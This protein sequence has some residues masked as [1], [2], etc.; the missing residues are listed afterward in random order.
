MATSGTKKYLVALDGSKESMA[1]V[2]YVAN[3]MYP[4][5]TQVR[6][7]HVFSRIP[8]SYWDFDPHPESDVWM[9]NLR[10]QEEAHEKEVKNFMNKALK[11]LLKADFREQLVSVEIHDRVNGIA[12]D[13][14]AEAKNNYHAV[15]MGRTGTGKLPGLAAGSVTSKILPALPSLHICVVAGKPQDGNI[16]V[17]IDGSEG[18][19]RAVDYLCSL[20]VRNNREVIL[21]HAMRHIGFTKSQPLQEIEKMVWR[22]AKKTIEPVIA[23]ATKRLVGAGLA[24]SK[25]RRKIVTG[26]NSRAGALIE[27]AKQSKCST[28]MVGRTGVSQVEAFNIGRVSNKV[29]H[30]AKNAAVWVIA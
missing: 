21:F 23:E 5:E 24:K 30:Q 26:V 7:F 25:I 8:E 16:L 11:R 28:I 29:I 18:S 9:K 12:R 19:M 6:L 10:T 1:T 3:V 27:E 20:K 2:D 15:I 4:S 13:I 22:D 14:I 17:A